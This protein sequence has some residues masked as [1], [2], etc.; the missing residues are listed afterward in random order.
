M[1]YRLNEEKTDEFLRTCLINNGI[2]AFCKEKLGSSRIGQLYDG[3][4]T[5]F[6][7]L[8]ELSDGECQM[9]RD[10][11]WSLNTMWV[12]WMFDRVY[13]VVEDDNTVTELGD[14]DLEL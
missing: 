6:F 8:R 4:F 14:R 9:D 10:E 7:A 13:D 1:I 3:E 12:G 2:Y 5:D 11:I